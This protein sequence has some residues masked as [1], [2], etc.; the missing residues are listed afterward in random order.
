MYTT[1]GIRGYGLVLAWAPVDYEA[2]KV[3]TDA[4]CDGGGVNT[5]EFNKYLYEGDYQ[6]ICGGVPGACALR[7]H[8]DDK[9]FIKQHIGV[10]LPIEE[11]TVP[12]VSDYLLVSMHFEIC[13]WDGFSGMFQYDPTKLKL[14][15]MRWN[16]AAGLSVDLAHFNYDSFFDRKP[17][18]LKEKMRDDPTTGIL[19]GPESAMVIDKDG[20][21]HWVFHHPCRDDEQSVV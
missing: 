11:V 6:S 12:K 5:E 2:F 15:T 3:L 21:F 16:F 19:P 7:V 14:Y 1:I 13:D 17:Y 4:D 18:L 20:M 10:D 9:P 8:C